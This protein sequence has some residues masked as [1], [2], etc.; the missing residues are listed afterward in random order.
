MQPNS[1]RY[2]KNKELGEGKEGGWHISKTKDFCFPLF[3]CKH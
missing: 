3:G 2:N 1:N